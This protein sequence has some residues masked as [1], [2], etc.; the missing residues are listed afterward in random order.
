M[1]R[2]IRGV[3]R[4]HRT[5]SRA[6]SQKFCPELLNTNSNRSNYSETGHHNPV[7]SRLTRVISVRS[8]ILH[9]SFLLGWQQ[10]SFANCAEKA[11]P[12]LEEATQ[13]ADF[14]KP[15]PTTCNYQRKPSGA[16][17]GRLRGRN[18]TCVGK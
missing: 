15:R 13:R 2:K 4:L 9:R 14:I 10:Y 18:D 11:V 17:R 1:H 6:T 5:Y 7:C 16:I 12:T 8:V 3:E